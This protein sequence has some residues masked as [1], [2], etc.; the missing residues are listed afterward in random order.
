[1]FFIIMYPR[2]HSDGGAASM[3]NGGLTRVAIGFQHVSEQD[4]FHYLGDKHEV[5]ECLL[6]FLFVTQTYR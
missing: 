4:D 6:E 5:A 3:P 2:R 1:M